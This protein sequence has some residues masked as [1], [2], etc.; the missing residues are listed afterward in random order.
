MDFD[1]F[2][3][4]QLLGCV[5]SALDSNSNPLT[6]QQDGKFIKSHHSLMQCIFLSGK[7]DLNCYVSL[8]G[9]HLTCCAASSQ[10]ETN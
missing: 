9:M 8:L 7:K 6:L 2:D 5:V 10:F 1:E 3:S 4:P